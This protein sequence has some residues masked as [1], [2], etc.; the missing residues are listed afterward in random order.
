MLGIAFNIV[1]AG[2]QKSRPDRRRLQGRGVN[3]ALEA[4]Y[5][6]KNYKKKY[7]GQFVFV[8]IHSLAPNGIHHIF[9]CHAF[10]R[11]AVSLGFNRNAITE[12][13]AL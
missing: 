2:Q 10:F 8:S 11:F 3:V 1:Q 6:L 4:M 9:G 13:E 7:P 12:F 5:M